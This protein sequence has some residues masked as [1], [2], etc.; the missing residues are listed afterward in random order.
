MQSARAMASGSR[1]T[2]TSPEPRPA[3]N[4]SIQAS[5]SPRLP[6]PPWEGPPQ[7]RCGIAY[8]TTIGT[9][10][11]AAAADVT[12]RTREVMVSGANSANHTACG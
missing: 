2:T 4:L 12:E 8:G 9:R 6:A 7:S 3:A 1:I 5:Y 11:W 10:P